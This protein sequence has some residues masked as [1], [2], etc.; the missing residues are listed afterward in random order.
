M[1]VTLPGKIFFKEDRA[2]SFTSLIGRLSHIFKK[3]F[4]PCYSDFERWLFLG[5]MIGQVI[6]AWKALGMK[7]KILE[8]K[9]IYIYH[10]IVYT[11]VFINK[12]RINK[13]K[14]DLIIKKYTS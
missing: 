1:I 14:I 7:D 10:L 6:L 5:G 3:L 2:I 13:F 4:A 11:K 8:K 12:L 9:S